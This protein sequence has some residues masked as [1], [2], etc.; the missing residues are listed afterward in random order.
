MGLTSQPPVLLFQIFQSCLFFLKFLLEY[1]CFTM[2][3]WF[4]L[5]RDVNQPYVYTYPP[6][7]WTSLPFSS[8]RELSWAS[9]VYSR[10]PL[11]I[12][13]THGSIL[14]LN[15]LPLG[16]LFLKTLPPSITDNS[17]YMSSPWGVIWA[18]PI[19]SKPST[20]VSL[21]PVIPLTPLEC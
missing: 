20:P 18:H 1:S 8:H 5:H 4:L 13:F 14:F 6:K 12:Y 17:A 19:Q 21:D 16:K 9:C 15:I 10:F 3:Y 2:L 11:A 7:P